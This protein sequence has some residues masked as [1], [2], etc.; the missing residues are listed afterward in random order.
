[1]KVIAEN[2]QYKNL[3]F[4]KE[5]PI[6]V[7]EGWLNLVWLKG[8]T[9]GH[10]L[11]FVYE[12]RVKLSYYRHVRGV[13]KENVRSEGSTST[14]ENWPLSMVVPISL[15]VIISFISLLSFTNQSDKIASAIL[16]IAS[17]IIGFVAH[18][19]LERSSDRRAN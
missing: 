8:Q 18:M 19:L 16:S 4:D 14:N 11:H 17:A 15:L 6:P 10:S 7:G 5:D 13:L 9:G 3:D 1:M 12:Q 2:R